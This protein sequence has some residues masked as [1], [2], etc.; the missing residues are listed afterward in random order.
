MLARLRECTNWVYSMRSFVQKYV[1][2]RYVVQNYERLA[3]LYGAFM[4]QAWR[5]RLNAK[6][7]W[8]DDG[9]KTTTIQ[10]PEKT[11][12]ICSSTPR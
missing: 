9:A 4:A 7:E 3:S 5:P 6:I 2:K 11:E 1:V 12:N 8:I 10:T